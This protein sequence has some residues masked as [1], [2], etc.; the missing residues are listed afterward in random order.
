MYANK[1]FRKDVVDNI[2]DI[3]VKYFWTDEFE[4]YTDRTAAE[5]TPAIQN[6]IGQLTTNPILRNIIGQPK[7]SIDFKDMINNKKIFLVNLAKGRIQRQTQQCSESF[8][9]ESFICILLREQI[10]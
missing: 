5:A 6:K 8:F 3:Q 7:T 10:F 1:A 9:L 4:R 2:K